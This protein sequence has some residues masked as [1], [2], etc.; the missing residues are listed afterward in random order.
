MNDDSIV[1]RAKGEYRH[2]RGPDC[3]V[4]IDGG[5]DRLVEHPH[6]RSGYPGDVGS[7]AVCEVRGCHWL[8]IQY[9]SRAWWK[10]IS[11]R[12]ARRI[13]RKAGTP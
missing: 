13:I 8:C 12:R 11:A 6:W 9:G 10:P 5:Y 7:I 2:V 1:Y 4:R 3:R